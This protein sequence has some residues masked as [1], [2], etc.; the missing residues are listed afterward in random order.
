M[1]KFRCTVT[2]VDEYEIEVDEKEMN[3]E[4]IKQFK[5]CFYQIETLQEHAEYIAELRARLNNNFMEG[6]GIPLV[7]GKNPLFADDKSINNAINIKIISE[8]DDIEVESVELV[9]A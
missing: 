4:F 3:E 7:N 6:Y 5:K 2:R 9:G 1:K 8:D